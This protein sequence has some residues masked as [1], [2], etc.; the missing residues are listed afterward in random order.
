[1]SR[2]ARDR[3]HLLLTGLSALA[4]LPASQAIAWRGRPVAGRDIL[5]VSA[6]GLISDRQGAIAVG[7]SYLAQYP[8]EADLD[9]LI[10]ALF[11]GMPQAQSRDGVETEVQAIRGWV[12]AHI[13][14][15]FRRA[16]IVTVGGWILAR[17]EARLCALASLA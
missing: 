12:A 7:R 8:N 3:R 13:E 2:F 6:A 9:R 14:E 17:S 11:A 15:D 4:V 5:A 1:M 16:R 10:D